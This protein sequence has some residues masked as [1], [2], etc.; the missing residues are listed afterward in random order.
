MTTR[1]YSIALARHGTTPWRHKV[2]N[3]ND[4]STAEMTILTKAL[5][6]AIDIQVK[7]GTGY[8]GE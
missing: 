3:E 4:E 5:R 1:H 7:L 6:N 2:A 8:R